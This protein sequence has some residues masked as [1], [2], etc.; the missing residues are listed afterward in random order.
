MDAPTRSWLLLLAIFYAVVV[1]KANAATTV[2]GTVFC[3]QCKDGHLSLFDYPISGIKVAVACP[4]SDQQGTIV[5][6]ETTNWL[7]TYSIKFDGTPDLSSCFVQPP[8]PLSFCPKPTSPA[9]Q[10]TPSPIVPDPVAPPSP[11]TPPPLYT[12]PPAFGLPP[13]PPMPYSEASAC[14]F[15]NW[16]MEENRC[17]WRAVNP[18]TKVAVLFGPLAAERYGTDTT[19]LQSLQ[20]GDDNLYRTLVREGTTAYLN[21]LNSLQFPYNTLAVVE[22]MNSALAGSERLVLFTALRFMRANSGS[23]GN[24][25]CRFTPCK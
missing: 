9:P 16:T 15:Q 11:P 17:Y 13:M 6:E 25:P 21:S 5:G 10:P 20:G 4:G 19:M 8:Q 18:D 14:P 3:D 22:H 1:Y 24:T 12:L 2:T 7:G 23:N